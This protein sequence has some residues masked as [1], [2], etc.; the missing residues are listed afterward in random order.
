MLFEKLSDREQ[1]LIFIVIATFIGG[2]YG[3]LRVAPE[4]KHLAELQIT[5]DKN[6]ARLN[7]P[8]I[9]D[10]PE[11]QV[12][13]LQETLEELAPELSISKV[14][15][16]NAQKNLAPADSQEMIL[17]ISEAARLAGVKVTETV[18]YVVQRKNAT[19]VSEAHKP[20]LSKRA[21]RKADRQARKNA[22]KA[23]AA[24]APVNAS[25][26]NP[27]EGELIYRLV[28]DL[29]TP[30]PFQRLSVEGN[31]A[32]VQK[33][34]QALRA[35]QWQATVVK[36]D[37]DVAIQTPPQGLPQPITARMLVAK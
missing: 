24:P 16:E 20:R 12:E 33:F 30:R 15:L 6:K 31:F 13:D 37:I 3:L 9:P 35:I 25:G 27:Q 5:V 1:V 28:N 10:E 14:A 7:N 23:G 26:G 29:D 34:I 22:Q 4:M 36:L 2:G 11:D 8:Q 18:P 19:V 17:K 21:Q 32:E